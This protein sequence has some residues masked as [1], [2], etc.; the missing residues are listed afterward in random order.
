MATSVIPYLMATAIRAYPAV[1][2]SFIDTDP[3]FP[4]KKR[5]FLNFLEVL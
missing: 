1:L 2:S 5:Q 4:I 3:T